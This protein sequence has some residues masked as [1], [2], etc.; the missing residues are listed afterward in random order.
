MLQI[1]ATPYVSPRTVSLLT[2]HSSKFSSL[3]ALTRTSLQV[4]F[5]RGTVILLEG[6]LL[7]AVFVYGCM[8]KVQKQQG[9]PPHGDSRL[10]LALLLMTNFSLLLVD[11]IHF[12]YNGL[13]LGM[14]CLS[15]LLM[16]FGGGSKGTIF[17]I[18]G[19]ALFA[20][21]VNAKHLFVFSGPAFAVYLLFG[22]IGRSR[23][24]Q[25]I[26]LC[27]L[28]SIVLLMCALSLGPFASLEQVMTPSICLQ[29]DF[30]CH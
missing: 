22:F 16:G 27:L 19:A 20:A 8:R 4:L 9:P 17:T 23:S 12:Q 10:A 21:L 25:F 7:L 3:Q 30:V 26:K 14:L 11:H 28:A 2:A 5:Q 24:N 6:T 1:S 29:M 13:L 15:M 18:L